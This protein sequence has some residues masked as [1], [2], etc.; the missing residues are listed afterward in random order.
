MA[1]LNLLFKQY[2]VH[3]IFHAA[4]YKHVPIIESNVIAGVKNN[5]IGTW[6]FATAAM[7]ANV[8]P[9]FSSRR[10]KQ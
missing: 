6:N 7:Q 9:L 4:A 5:V 3:T 8:R 2:C 10:T 1:L